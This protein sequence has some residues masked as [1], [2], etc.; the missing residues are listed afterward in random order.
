MKRVTKIAIAVGTAL[1]LGLAAAA[2]SA[3]PNGY[4]PGWGGGHMGGYMQG[5]G[6]GMMGGY[7]P[8]YG[9]GPGMMGGYGPGYGMGPGMMG[10]YGP[11]YGMHAWGNPDEN[12]AAMKAELGITDKQDGAWQAFANNAKKQSESR[13]AWFAKM[14]EARSAGSAPEV[15]AQRTEL[16]KQRQAEMEANTAALKD[17]Y[18]VLTPDQKTIADQRFGGFGPGYGAGYGRGYGGPRGYQR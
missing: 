9:M 15:L 5:Y 11:G 16:M 17:L 18:A 6:P 3:H 2:V 12:L 4:G 14:Q 1:S 10:G 7:G 13:Q 8:G